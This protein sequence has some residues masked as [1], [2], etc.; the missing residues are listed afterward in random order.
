MAAFVLIFMSALAPCLADR[1]RP[2]SVYT[3]NYPLQYFAAR[4]AAEHAEAIL[5][6]PSDVDPAFWRPSAETI[7]AFQKA[8]L[9][10]LNGAGYARWSTLASLPRSR[11][12]DTSAGFREKLIRVEGSAAHRHGPTGE[13]D[14][15]GTAF[16]TWLDFELAIRQA[17][18]I[19][20]AL[21]RLLPEAAS[22]FEANFSTL[23][24]ELTD[25][26]HMVAEASGRD[27]DRAWLA[28]HP[29]YQ[30]LARA[31]GLKVDAVTWEPDVYP[32][33]SEWRRLETL[34]EQ[35]PSRW[36]L[37]EAEPRPETRERLAALRVNVVVFDPCFN[38]RQSGDFLEVMRA[39][40]RDLSRSY[41]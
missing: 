40:V 18:A 10:L 20:D 9:I 26:G 30:Y 7:I 29:V 23:E 33:E 11:L 2:L 28:S 32:S 6:V 34:L 25:L 8:D 3:V 36:M 41:D 13:H 24:R 22:T 39:N 17:R 4:I 14:H 5:P 31:H 19:A 15:G 35:R 27:P 38:V 1:A 37:W 21:S 16:T 12:L